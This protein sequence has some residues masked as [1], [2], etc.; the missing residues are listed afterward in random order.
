MPRN[1]I[2]KLE[3]GCPPWAE[4]LSDRER[5]FV[6]SYIV[7]L[8]PTEAAVRAKLARRARVRLK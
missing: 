5:A 8:N 3:D 7:D 1:T 2:A 4:G 6:E